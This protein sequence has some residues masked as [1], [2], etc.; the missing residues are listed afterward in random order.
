[1]PEDI[2]YKP[3]KYN[4]NAQTYY[5]ILPD[6]NVSDQMTPASVEELQAHIQEWSGKPQDDWTKNY[7]STLQS[8]LGKIQSGQSDYVSEYTM[9][10]GEVGKMVPKTQIADIQ[11][12]QS[13]GLPIIS[14]Q[15]YN[16]QGIEQIT[17]A[18]YPGEDISKKYQQAT[19]SAKSSGITSPTN[20]EGA[21]DLYRSFLGQGSSTISNFV[22]QDP[23]LGS[24]IKTFQDY[25]SQ[26][27]QRTS[28]VDTYKQ[29]LADTGIEQ[30]DTDL[31]NM[32]NVIEG[33]EDDIRTE[34]TKAG[35]FAT[36]S[37][38]MALTNARNKQLIKN[39]NALLE[40]RN[41]KA[42]YLNT[43]MNLTQQDRAEADA[44][45]E[46]MMN[47]EFK[48]AEI[49]QQ[50]KQNAIST[51]DRVAQTLGWDGVY[52]ATGGNPQLIAQI[53][54]TY[55]LPSGSLAIAAQRDAE[56]R[57]QQQ[58]TQALD[59][60]YRQA[61]L[62][63]LQQ[64][65]TTIIE[66]G[67][68]QLLINSQTGEVIKDLGAIQKSSTTQTAPTVKS[69]S[70]I[71]S[72]GDIAEGQ[73]ALEKSRGMPYIN[74]QT[75]QSVKPTGT[76]A[77]YANSALYLKMLQK[78]I[79]NGGLVQDFFTQ[80]PP[81]NYLNPNDASIPQWIRDKLKKPTTS[82]GTSGEDEFDNL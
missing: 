59:T 60:Q 19:Q 48:I 81:K 22:S 62:E 38:V 12:A 68:R 58:Q 41:N 47:F 15:E 52:Q 46:T 17:P 64:P 20:A 30:M 14:P 18:S 73:T 74:E 13:G 29:M 67:G 40:T 82:G 55:G 32:K 57:G 45:F 50:M 33:S 61:Q 28:L 69:G 27:N 42:Q 77:Q 76:D 23:Y 37:Q 31:L 4:V 56:I 63:N 3:Y 7:L 5:D 66:S 8:G 21:N 6:Y 75:Q 25:M 1:M 44:R 65:N 9:P 49:N 16:A 35:G 43:I 70:L 78:W 10:W 24:V 26:Q 2:K 71:V 39:Y 34:I 36:E 53:E 80:Y 79:D 11:K 72:E 51:I 54:R